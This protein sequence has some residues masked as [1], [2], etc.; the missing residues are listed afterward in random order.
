MAGRPPK[1]GDSDILR[2]FTEAEDPVLTAKE[3]AEGLPIQR[4]SVY[5]RLEDLVETGL[6]GV[7]K[8]GQSAKVYWITDEGREYLEASD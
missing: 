6:V 3:V 8:A 7:K 2:R 5:K 1:V 4:Q